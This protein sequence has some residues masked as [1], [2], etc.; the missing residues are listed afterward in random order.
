MRQSIIYDFSKLNLK[1]TVLSKRKLRW[2]VDENIVE[3]WNDPRFPTVQGIMRRGMTVEA[4]KGFML[5]QGPS[6]NTNLQEWDK[7]WANNKSLIDPVVPRYTAIAKE[8]AC[9]LV[10]ENGPQPSEGRTQD[11]HPKDKAVGSKVVIFSRNLFIERD[12]ASSIQEGEKI[13]LMKWGNATVTRKEVGENGSITLFANVDEADKDFKGTKKVTW[14]SADKETTTE[15]K[16]LEFGHLIT[17]EKV[18]DND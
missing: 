8:S 6:K 10:I 11:L 15:I 14:I 17:K 2:F 3:G 4:L 16:I 1:S 18:E 5:E 9:K 7:I 13:T 12:D